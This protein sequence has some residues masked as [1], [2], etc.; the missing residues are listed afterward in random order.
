MLKYVVIAAIL[1]ITSVGN[2]GPFLVCDPP[3]DNPEYAKIFEDG[4]E[5][6]GNLSLEADKS[7]KYDLLGVL[8][9]EHTYTAKYCNIRGCSDASNPYVYPSV[10]AAPQGLGG[11]Q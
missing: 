11:I 5:I 7:I 1:L 6:K 10:P 9:G 8:P 4:T 2:T 3:T